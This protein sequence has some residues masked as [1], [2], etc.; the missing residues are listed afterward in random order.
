MK[1]KALMAAAVGVC[2]VTLVAVQAQQRGKA[3]T[4]TALDYLE[5]QQL[6]AQYAYALDTGADSGY[7]YARLF[8]PDGVFIRGE[9]NG[10]AHIQGRE[11]L[12]SLA[13][14]APGGSR[15]PLTVG[16]YIV[17]HV[18][19]PAPQGATGKEYLAY[20]TFGKDGQQGK[21]DLGGHYEDVYVKTVEGW[22]FKSRQFI[23]SKAGSQAEQ[24]PAAR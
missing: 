12:A 5:I 22:R 3:S 1:S 7:A 16:H 2:A 13:R 21:I 19:D 11:Q 20:L 8:A 18:I 23:E 10:K 17:N 6:V 9:S 24:S 14:V 15:G 4:L